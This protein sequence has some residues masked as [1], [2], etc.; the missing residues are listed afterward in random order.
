VD[1]VLVRHGSRHQHVT[2][3]DSGLTDHGYHQIQALAHALRLRQ[4]EVDCYLSSRSRPAQETTQVLQ[5]TLG[6]HS[7]PV[8]VLSCLTPDAGPGDVATLIEEAR[9]AVP[10]LDRRRCVVLVGHEGRLSDLVTELTGR[11]IR[12][13]GHGEAVCVRGGCPTDLV[14]GRADVHFR[15]PTFDHQEESLQSKVQSKMTVSTLLAGF[16]FTALSGLL[17][18]SPGQWRVEQVIAVIALASS[19]A[20]FVASVYIYDQL[21]MPTGFWTDAKRPRLW[22]RIYRRAEHR[23]EA[24]WHAI[25]AVE[26]PDAADEDVRPWLQDGPR[27]HLMIRTSRLLFIPGTWLALVGFLALLKGTGDLRIL[28]GAFTGLVIAGGFALSRRPDLGAD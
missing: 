18:L 24:R 2:E 21:G 28:A 11:R 25:A 22:A 15:Y 27:Y 13:V 1:F 23:R 16:V 8:H 20:L 7:V 12:P 19:L 5:K 9:S 4:S 14:A 10:D 17:L 26:G 6:G 3:A